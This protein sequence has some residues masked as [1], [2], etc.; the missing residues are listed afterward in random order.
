V[1]GYFV[2]WKGVDGSV[3]GHAREATISDHLKLTPAQLAQ[4]GHLDFRFGVKNCGF[5]VTGF[6]LGGGDQTDEV[7]MST[8]E[9]GSQPPPKSHL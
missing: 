6:H 7:T 3:G 9:C 1:L 2:Q 8:V 4:F 5:K